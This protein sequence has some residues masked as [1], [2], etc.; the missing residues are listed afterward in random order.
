ML[1]ISNM[2]FSQEKINTVII[3]VGQ[4]DNVVVMEDLQYYFSKSADFKVDFICESQRI[5]VISVYNQKF[6]DPM[7]V[8]YHLSLKFDDTYFELKNK[9]ILKTECHDEYVK[10]LNE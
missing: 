6:K 2:V 7:I 4:S 10:Y 8:I 1:L 9:N 5:F 3:G